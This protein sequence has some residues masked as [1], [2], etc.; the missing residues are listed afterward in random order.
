MVGAVAGAASTALIVPRLSSQATFAPV[1]ED[2]G[3]VALALDVFQALKSGEYA[4]VE[5]RFPPKEALASV[6]PAESPFIIRYSEL[7][8][9]LAG[10]FEQCRIDYPILSNSELV[11]VEGFFV[12][13]TSPAGKEIAAYDN[14]HLY[15]QSDGMVYDIKLDEL[16]RIDGVWYLVE[17][18]GK[19]GA[20]TPKPI[21]QDMRN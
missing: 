9:K 16:L 7:K 3:P 20:G 8:E 17:L 2:Q 11:R 15:V 12:T 1:I 10:E 14:A 18:P 19:E 5:K 13:I 4:V 6:F 21:S